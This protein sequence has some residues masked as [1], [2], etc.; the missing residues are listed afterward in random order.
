MPF[1]KSDTSELTNTERQLVFSFVGEAN[2]ALE[3]IVQPLKMASLIA[4]IYTEPICQM[5]KSMDLMFEPMRR[6]QESFHKSFFAITKLAE[7][8]ALMA[9]TRKEIAS[10]FNSVLK[11]DFTKF[12]SIGFPPSQIIEAGIEEDFNTQ[13]LILPSPQL[14]EHTS[15]IELTPPAQR[16][17]KKQNIFR[18]TD[19]GFGITLTI[20]GRFLFKDKLIKNFSTNSKHGKFLEML[21][22]APNNYVLDSDAIAKLEVVDPDKGLGYIRNDLKE[23]F[24]KNGIQINLYRQRK[25]GYRLLGTKKMSN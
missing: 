16:R 4:E 2:R 5:Q 3:R 6:M 11:A 19:Y 10:H 22:K 14:Q 17:L 9:E 8:V 7:S 21:L 1:L 12:A 13:S 25:K 20:E 23:S 24:A 18:G 15:A